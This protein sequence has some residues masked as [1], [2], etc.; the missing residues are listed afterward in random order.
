MKIC[1][2][3]PISMPRDVYGR[4]YEL[5]MKDYELFKDTDTEII[6]KDV[7]TGIEDFRLLNFLGF[8]E[9][10]DIEV[11]KAM[12]KAETEGYDGVA[13]ACYFDSGIKAAS[14]LL[15]IPVVGPAEA[16][17][18]LACMMGKDFTVITSEPKWI[19]E[20]E[21][22][23]LEQGFGPFAI[24]N[25]PVRSMTIPMNEMFEG[26]MRGSYDA[27]IKNFTEVG[28][29]S[30][31]DGAQVIIAGCGLVSPV[32]S[33]NRINEVE[34]APIIDPMIASLKM[35]EMMVTL[36]RAGMPVKSKRGLHRTPVDELRLKGIKEL[37]LG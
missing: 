35:A 13:G 1:C 8:R 23:L 36:A 33:V 24:S 16:S 3:L 32:F 17:M 30:L 21:H 6:I 28:R 11:V 15:S 29:Q 37:R 18:H 27:I 25:N 14:N 19:K 10:N 20:M 22:Y 7:P 26:L 34:G 9:I 12:V 31:D 5:L 2:Q 4:H